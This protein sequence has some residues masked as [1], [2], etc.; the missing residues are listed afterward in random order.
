MGPW[1]FSNIYIWSPQGLAD[2]EV[3][4]EDE[5]EDDGELA[6]VGEEEEEDEQPIFSR[7]ASSGPPPPHQ[8]ALGNG[9]AAYGYKDVFGKEYERRRQQQ[10]DTKAS[11]PGDREAT[12]H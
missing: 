12:C 5:D 9:K 10:I 4:V 11:G 8:T 7:T 6:G 3:D 2:E 1:L